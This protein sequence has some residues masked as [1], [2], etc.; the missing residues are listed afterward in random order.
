M[1]ALKQMLIG[2]ELIYVCDGA[3]PGLVKGL[4]MGH[5][6]QMCNHLYH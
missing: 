1:F 3:K 4:I 5:S 2:G 6:L